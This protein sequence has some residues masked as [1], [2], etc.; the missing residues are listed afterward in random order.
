MTFAS[1]RTTYLEILS[2]LCDLTRSDGVAGDVRWHADYI[3]RTSKWYRFRGAGRAGEMTSQ[4]RELDVCSGKVRPLSP[5]LLT[6]IFLEFEGNGLIAA[7]TG[8]PLPPA[9]IVEGLLRPDGKVPEIVS[10][11]IQKRLIE[12]G[13]LVNVATSF[14]FIGYARARDAEE[15]RPRLPLARSPDIVSPSWFR[16]RIMLIEHVP[17]AHA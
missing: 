9:V 8:P 17:P 7:Y 4:A 15:M 13:R 3:A 5:A 1:Y 16:E 11:S 10:V 14:V 6:F 2:E 12:H